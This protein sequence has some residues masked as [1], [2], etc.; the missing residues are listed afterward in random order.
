VQ[1][2]D[3]QEVFMRHLVAVKASLDAKDI[4][5][6]MTRADL[7]AFMVEQLTDPTWLRK[8]PVIGY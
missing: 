7:A 2:D 1:K 5:G 4:R 6:L 8:S 3:L